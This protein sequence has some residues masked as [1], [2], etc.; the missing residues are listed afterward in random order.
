[1]ED[2]NAYFKG[3]TLYGDDFSPAQAAE[4]YSDEREGYAGLAARGGGSYRYIYHALNNFHGFSRLPS[5]R[6]PEVMGFGSAY[7]EE[8]LPV[9]SQ[10]EKITVVD[11]S[12]SF[13]RKEIHGVPSEYLKPGSGGALPLAGEKFDL[14]TCLGVLHHIPK[15]S[16]AV[17]ELFRVLRPGGYMVLREPVISLGDWR[18]RRPGLTLRE[19]GIPLGILEEILISAGFLVES[20][21]LCGFPLTPR[22]F[23]LLRPDFYNSFTAVRTDALL[24]AAFAFNYR[25]HARG[26]LGKIRPTAAFFVLKK[27]R[28]RSRGKGRGR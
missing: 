15:V 26:V 2:Y 3:E 8:F 20:R 16:Y 13:L 27:P 18:R 25:Y 21:S 11:P 10:V 22:L 7:G 4:W 28:R 19:R 14:I 24:A 12:D 23:R 17:S 5:R 6:F 9:I 1:M